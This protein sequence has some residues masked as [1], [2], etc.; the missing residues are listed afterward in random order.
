MDQSKIWEHFQNQEGLG[1]VF[2]GART[3]YEFLAKQV[4]PKLRVLNIGVGRGGLESILQ[5]KGVVVSCLD[6]SE[7]SIENIRN[8]L[9]LENRAKVGY[10][11]AMPFEDREFDF[12]IMSEVIEHLSNEI[13]QSTLLEVSRVLKTGGYFMGTVPADEKLIDNHAMCPHCGETFHRWGHV[14]SF[15]RQRLTQILAKHFGKTTISRHFFGD[16]SSLNWKGRIA[17]II[18]K[19]MVGLGIVGDGETYFFLA[20]KR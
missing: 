11:Q 1:D 12:V 13:L 19:S 10:S 9:S 3:R 7:A 2:T 17:L 15:S 6:P 8:Q 4:S 14:Q 5:K 16:W 18:K 20:V